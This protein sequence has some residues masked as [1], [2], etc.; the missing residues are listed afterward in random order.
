M[1]NG[2]PSL[3]IAVSIWSVIGLIFLSLSGCSASLPSAS[4]S[5][6]PNPPGNDAIAVS[7]NH[8]TR[9]SSPW[10]PHGL[11]FIAFVQPPA[12]QPGGC[13]GSTSG[14]FQSA[15]N[16]YQADSSQLFIG[17]AAW[18]SDT[19]RFQ[20]SQEG[21]D[22][23]S[24]IYSASF[25]NSFVQAVQNARSAGLNVIVSLQDECQSGDPATT[26]YPDARNLRVWTALAPQFR[27]DLGIMFEIYN[28][29]EPA[30][31]TADWQT[32]KTTFNN[33]IAA[34]RS[35]GTKNVVI[36]DG[37][38]FATTLSGAPDLTDSA[39][40][41]AY[42]VHPYFHQANLT[43]SFWDAH[44]GTFAATHPVIVTEWTTVANSATSGSSY[45]CDSNTP[46]QAL[47]LL[48]YLQG[49][50][51]GMLGFTWDFTGS[52]FGSAVYYTSASTKTPLNSTFAAKQ[53]GD[54]GYGPGNTL[55]SWF[56]TGTVP[57]TPQ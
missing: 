39:D 30:A 47:S 24:N 9:G 42:A 31:N 50:G 51:I 23:Q 26:N 27:N 29:P 45:Y 3:Y 54:S 10:A 48:G 12:V 53:C 40:S 49:H 1:K 44:F 32:W 21:L 4:T 43:P 20:V 14:V 8:L 25:F 7:G 11:N 41:V 5:S 34:I 52:V 57:S 38:E 55:Q 46:S 33:I 6:N 35:T 2:N 56:Q 22:P 15:W 37:L 16:R 13:D 28:E 19:I 36:A 18:G 17:L